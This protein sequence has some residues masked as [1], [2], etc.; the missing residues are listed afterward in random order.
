MPCKIMYKGVES[1]IAVTKTDT[2]NLE[3]KLVSLSDSNSNVIELYYA[4]ASFRT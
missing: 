4:N 3:S 2:R 1:Y